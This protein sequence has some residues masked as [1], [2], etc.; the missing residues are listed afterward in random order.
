MSF[1][2]HDFQQID[3]IVGGMGRNFMIRSERIRVTSL[4]IVILTSAKFT[5]PPRR[6]RLMQLHVLKQ[7]FPKRAFL[8]CIREFGL[9]LSQ[10]PIYTGV[11]PFPFK[12]YKRWN[13]SYTNM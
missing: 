9:Y 5:Y 4:E 8:N 7:Q 6:M 1:V 13:A 2:Y 3:T 11:L 10:H 12:R